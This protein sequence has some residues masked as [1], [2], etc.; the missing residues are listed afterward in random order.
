MAQPPLD[1]GN[2]LEG[3]QLHL[4]GVQDHFQGIRDEVGLIANMPAVVD[5]GALQQQINANQLQLVALFGQMQGQI[6][7]L[8]GQIGDMQGQMGQMQNE[9]Q[10]LPIRLHNSTISNHAPLRYPVGIQ[11]GP[12]LPATRHALIQ[13]TGNQCQAVAVLLHLPGLPAAAT[14]AQRR[15]QIAEYLGVQ[16]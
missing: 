3:V 6:G 10:I 16:L 13:M 1:I 11:V 2:H 5:V 12:P 9:Q 15:E 8:Q 7:D 4:Q 14:V